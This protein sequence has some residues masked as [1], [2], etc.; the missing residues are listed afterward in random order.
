MN[1]AIIIS[2]GASIPG[3]EAKG[4]EVF[5]DALARFD[6]YA[7]NGRVHSHREYFALTGR[8]GGYVIIDGE[9]DELTTILTEDETI[10]LNAQAAAVVN[11]FHV[12]LVGGGTEDAVQQV[13]GTYTG[14]LQT[15]G[16]L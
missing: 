13:M 6:G 10:T 9:L 12:Q 14:A 2:W 3:R 16:Y 1:G 11:D 7:K 5:G 15:I 4:L 8:D